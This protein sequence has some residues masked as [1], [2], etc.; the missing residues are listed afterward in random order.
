MILLIVTLCFTFVACKTETPEEVDAEKDI[1]EVEE[2]ISLEEIIREYKTS[3]DTVYT[4]SYEGERVNL[5]PETPQI[6]EII[7]FLIKAS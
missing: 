7:V 3:E 5:S 1:E 6:K 4:V 2:E